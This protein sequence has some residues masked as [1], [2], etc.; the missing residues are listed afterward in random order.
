MGKYA[1]L[2]AVNQLV[3]GGITVLSLHRGMESIPYCVD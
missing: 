2:I 1:L 3:L